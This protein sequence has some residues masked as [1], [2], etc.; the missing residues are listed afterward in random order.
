MNPILKIFRFQF[1]II[2]FGIFVLIAGYVSAQDV[3][4]ASQRDSLISA[5]REYMHAARF[6]ALITI[7]SS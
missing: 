2:L 4:S 1:E 5:A 6:C 3:G 7:D